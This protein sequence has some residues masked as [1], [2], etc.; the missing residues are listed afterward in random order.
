MRGVVFLF[1][2]FVASLH[3]SYSVASPLNFTAMSSFIHSREDWWGGLTE[4]LWPRDRPSVAFLDGPVPKAEREFVIHGWRW[5]TMSVLRDLDRLELLLCDVLSRQQEA[6]RDFASSRCTLERITAGHDFT[7][8]F[9]MRAL[10][11]VEEDIFVPL[12]V[13]ILPAE[14]MSDLHEFREHH[15]LARRLAVQVD[16]H[17]ASLADMLSAQSEQRE[18]GSRNEVVVQISAKMGTGMGKGKDIGVNAAATA[19]ALTDVRRQQVASTIRR[20]ERLVAQIRGSVRRT[21]S[22]QQGVFDPCIAAH[23]S[24]KEQWVYNNKVI[25]VLG[26]IDAQVHL[27]SFHEAIASN[28]AEFRLYKSQIPRIAQA[29]IPVWK[30]S[31]YLPRT[32][33]FSLTKSREC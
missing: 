12:L 23:L 27:V 7:C 20:I 15:K 4:K 25:S 29:L 33:C 30:S 2:L 11:R 13:R 14:A 10:Q 28:P 16:E 3:S 5:H 22:V 1:T 19:A 8:N 32:R 18:R 17:F 6:L 21:H 9:N 26:L 31:L 24:V